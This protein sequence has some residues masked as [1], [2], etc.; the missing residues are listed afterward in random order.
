MKMNMTARKLTLDPSFKDRAAKKLKKLDR[1]FGEDAD[2]MVTVTPEHSEVTVEIVV[3][4]DNM[5]FRAERTALDKNDALENAVDL[6]FKQIV[7]NK[8]KLVTRLKADAFEAPMDVSWEEEEGDYKVVRE[9]RFDIGVM[10]VQE[11]ILQMNLLGH[12]FFM[13]RNPD[14]GGKINVVYRR[15]NDDYGLLVPN[16]R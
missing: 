5:I 4:A 7:K 9:K 1:F 14:E 16:E 15:R 8:S 11:A 2:V 12:S 13:F 10:T 3:R 6:L